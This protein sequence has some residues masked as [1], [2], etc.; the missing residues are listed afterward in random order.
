MCVWLCNGEYRCPW[1]SGECTR[2]PG[3]G[4]TG[5]CEMNNVG[6]EEW[7][8][9]LYKSSGF[10]WPSHPS[11]PL[12]AYTNLIGK[13]VHL[14]RQDDQ[15][16][17]KPAHHWGGQGRQM[18][19]WGQPPQLW[20]GPVWNRHY[21]YVPYFIINLFSFCILSSWLLAI[22]DLFLELW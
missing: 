13:A 2:Y 19:S 18:V 16:R 20:W 10:W 14:A 5:S 1:R 8:L 17:N 11:S 22:S 9:V 4:M 3:A 6:A 7:T 21:K 15:T 12:A